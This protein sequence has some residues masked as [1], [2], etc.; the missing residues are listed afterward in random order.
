MH[1]TSPV[2]HNL[3]S[4][5]FHSPSFH[6]SFR[7]GSARLPFSIVTPHYTPTL[8]ICQA[9]FLLQMMQFSLALPPHFN[10]NYA[11]TDKAPRYCFTE[12]LHSL[13]PDRFKIKR[14][15]PFSVSLRSYPSLLVVSYQPHQVLSSYL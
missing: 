3:K 14:T 5:L 6:S 7:L 8:S 9:L 13:S 15:I 2:N 1:F 10:L 11:P 12:Q 4:N